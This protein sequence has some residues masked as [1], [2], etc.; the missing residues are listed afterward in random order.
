MYKALKVEQFKDIT[1][2]LQ[3]PFVVIGLFIGGM[4]PY[5]FGGMAMMAVGRAAGRVAIADGLGHASLAPALAQRSSPK[6]LP[7]GNFRS[8]T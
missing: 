2:P 1:F 4:L 5:A 8:K 6:N 7:L 3:E